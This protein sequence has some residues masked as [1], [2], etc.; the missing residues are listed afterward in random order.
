MQ[1][2]TLFAFHIRG[3][4]QG[5]GFRPFISKLCYAL[6]LSGWV[7]N[8][9]DGVVGQV[10][11]EKSKI[12]QFLAQVSAEAPDCARIFSIVPVEVDDSDRPTGFQIRFSQDCGDQITLV[13]PDL[14]LCDDCQQEL[15]GESRRT[16]HPFINCTHCGPRYSIIQQLPYDR[17]HTTM[18]KF[19][20]C[21]QCENEYTSL[22][23]RRFHAEPNACHDC[24]PHYTFKSLAGDFSGMSCVSVAVDVL[25]KGGVL[26]V[27]GL[28]GFHLV[29]SALNESAVNRL[30]MEKHRDQ[31]PFA[32]MFRDR[33]HLESYVHLASGELDVLLSPESPIVLL[34]H[35]L[36]RTLAPSVNPRLCHIGAMLPYT[37]LQVLLMQDSDMPPLIMTSANIAQD[38]ILIE[39]DLA[40]AQWGERLDGVIVSDRAIHNRCDDSVV[41]IINQIRYMIRRARGYV[42]DP[43]YMSELVEGFMAV[44]AELKST[45]C[46]GRERLALMSPHIGDLKTPEALVFFEEVFDRLR[47]LFRFSPQVM[48]HDLHPDYESTRWALKS[49]LPCIGVQ[50][51]HAHIAAVM[52]EHDVRHKVIGI[53][54]DGVGFGEDGTL[55]GGEW[56]ES[57]LLTYDRIGHLPYLTLIGGDQA[58][59]EPWRLA[60]AVLIDQGVPNEDVIRLLPDIVPE[61][62]VP[63][64]N[65]RRSSVPYVRSCSAGRWFDAIAALLG[66]CSVQ[67]YEGQAPMI[68][69]Q[70]IDIVDAP[71][72]PYSYG[73]GS[74]PLFSPMIAEMITDIEAGIPRGLMSRR[75]HDT[76]IT[77]VHDWALL[78]RENSGLNQVVLSGGVF[79]N[80]YL[81]TRLIEYLK[82]SG[83]EVLCAERFPCND[84]GIS[85]GQLAIGAARL[86]VKETVCV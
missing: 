66:F 38:P 82:S 14:R 52:A 13:P 76:I 50:H 32:V 1:D 67:E 79:Q 25:R 85:L 28:G 69:E 80:R 62:L 9:V 34:A 29:C 22:S 54:L 5:V 41:M 74:I 57:D 46:F 71:L 8:Q 26:A 19:A 45:F 36:Y 43:Q 49:G 72:A 73:K 70:A 64:I 2:K 3:R 4:V 58:V 15:L 55:W 81:L 53:A 78:S 65:A 6:G 84:G 42:P 24:G 21:S 63:V 31:K 16:G 47:Q 44:G 27:K 61:K 60:L 75:F 18:A 30:R 23:D 10:E 35:R 56:F 7:R 51:H 11:G 83:L 33:D 20:Q 68:M 77:I 59:T 48:V 12:D 40:W 17:A 86:K 37:P 39:D